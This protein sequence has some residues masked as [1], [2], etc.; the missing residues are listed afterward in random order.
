MPW[1]SD[2][3]PVSRLSTTV[4]LYIQKRANASGKRRDERSVRR[5]SELTMYSQAQVVEN[6]SDSAFVNL[7]RGIAEIATEG[8]EDEFSYDIKVKEG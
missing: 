4:G 6:H 7:G 2:A 8:K 5:S 1:H 3:S